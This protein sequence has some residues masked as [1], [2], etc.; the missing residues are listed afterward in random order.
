MPVLLWL[1]PKAFEQIDSNRDG[2]IDRNVRA[3]VFVCV[4]YCLVV[5]YALT[6]CRCR[7][8][9]Q[10]LLQVLSHRQ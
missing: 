7:S 3:C 4:V 1:Q 9:V 2:L 6:F 10:L 8:S 5:S